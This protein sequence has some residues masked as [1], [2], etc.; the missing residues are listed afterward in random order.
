MTDER[1]EKVTFHHFGAK[2]L[3]H[4]LYYYK[5]DFVIVTVIVWIKTSN[6][7]QVEKITPKLQ[8]S[9]PNE[10]VLSRDD[11]RSVEPSTDR[12]EDNLK[13]VYDNINQHDLRN[14]NPTSKRRYLGD[15][16]FPNFQYQRPKVHKK[17]R[18]QY[19]RLPALWHFLQNVDEYRLEAKYT[20][21]W[22]KPGF[23]PFS[24][25]LPLRH[26]TKDQETFDMYTQCAG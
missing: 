1:T 7:E 11:D 4:D 24:G 19:K 25:R 6:T 15:D 17:K 2:T 8:K 9:N 5:H 26:H 12:L 18:S 14:L 23:H 3:K 20:P 16:I 21:P 22:L 10:N 13:L